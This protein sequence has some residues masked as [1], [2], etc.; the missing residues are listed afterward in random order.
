[1]FEVAS[2]LVGYAL[3]TCFVAACTSAPQPVH[4]LVDGDLAAKARESRLESTT[5]ARRMTGAGPLGCGCSH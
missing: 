3:V 5:G 1:M 4:P 2:R